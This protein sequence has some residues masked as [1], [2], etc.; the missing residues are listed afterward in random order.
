MTRLKPRTEDT[1]L[2]HFTYTACLLHETI[3]MKPAQGSYSRIGEVL[4][5]LID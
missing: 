4:K 1:R 3:E 2:I 5:S